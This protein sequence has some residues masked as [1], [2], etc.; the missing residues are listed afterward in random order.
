MPV[1]KISC[2]TDISTNSGASAWIGAS[3][4]VGIGPRSSIGSPMTLIIRPRVSAPTG[5]LMGYPLSKTFWPRTS[6]SVPENDK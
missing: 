2:S 6:P 5:I 1:T 3:L 4:S